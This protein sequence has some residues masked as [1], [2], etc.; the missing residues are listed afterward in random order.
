M[1]KTGELRNGAPPKPRDDAADRTK[2]RYRPGRR[3]LVSPLTWRILTVNVIALAVLVAALLYVGQ[4]ERE[5]LDSELDALTIQGEIFSGALGQSAVGTGVDGTQS[6]RPA[7]SRPMLRRLVQPTRTRARLYGMDG[8]LI[9]D[10]RTLVGPGGK[11]EVE[12][13]PPPEKEGVIPSAILSLYRRIVGWL[14]ASGYN[15]P[16]IEHA[17][18]RASD[19]AE[20]VRALSGEPTR[21]VRAAPN[22]GLVL[23]SAVP[24]QR[25]K[26]VLGAL[27]L[28]TG[29]DEI[30]RAVSEVRIG[31]LKVFGVSLAITVLLSLYLANAITRPVR[32]LA[33]A[34]E[35]VRSGQSRDRTIPDFTRRDDE[36]GDLSGALR[37]MTEAL[38]NR[39][40]A[41]ESFA[42]DV[43]HE[44][45][46]PLTSLRSAVETVARVT[47]PEQQRQLMSI[48]QEDVKRLD[49][50]ISDISSAS[51]LDAELA[52]ADMDRV[53]LGELLK[54][55]VQVHEST[56]A[57]DQLPLTL[58]LADGLALSV[59]GIEIR[60]VQVLQNLITNAVS[61]SP[62]DG[63]VRMAARR[64]GDMI[65][66]SVDDD[67]PGIPEDN[68]D[69]IFERF[70]SERPDGEQFGTHSGLGLSISRQIVE[71]HGGTITVTNRRNGDGTIEGAHFTIRL[72]SE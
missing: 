65:E 62:P 40:E 30:E 27:L 3:G 38:W 25:F 22:G 53:D 46:N 48:I 57:P 42:A 58:D 45:K 36:I 72:P 11:V 41:I 51:R 28:T 21:G 70:Y 9:A 20:A 19:Y 54:A 18:Q 43:A 68:L 37:D 16:Y 60:L 4:Y 24:V 7:V 69:S 49:R 29:S 64:D 39:M 33:A 2:S 17:K 14:P 61:F 6:L 31:I 50:L 5:L 1:N 63:S 13:L 56:A 52:R 47:D 66:V 10:S 35:R 34:A 8:Q 26:Q 71:A 23:I 12:S 15:E 67:G 44:I 32:R 59:H 55:L